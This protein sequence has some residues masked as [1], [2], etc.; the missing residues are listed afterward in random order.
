MSPDHSFDEDVGLDEGSWVYLCTSVDQ[1]EAKRHLYQRVIEAC[2]ESGW[3]A[4]SWSSPARTKETDPGRFFQGVRHAV[5]HADVVVAFIDEEGDLAD[6]E[7]A[8]AY[9]HRRPVVGVNL[10]G[11]P[12]SS[13]GAMLSGY[14]RARF[15][16]CSSADEC[17]TGLRK[18]LADPDFSETIRRAAGEHLTDA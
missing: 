17:F 5:E 12:P 15:V 18:I 4:V 1:I 8:L 3:P 14:E 2:E 11:K 6:I 7:L 13:I 9:S 10:S 16:N